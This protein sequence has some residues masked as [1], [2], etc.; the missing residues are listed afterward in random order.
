M[1]EACEHID[2]GANYQEPVPE[3]FQNSRNRQ[4]LHRTSQ[5]L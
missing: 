4:T 5:W 1:S 3:D 2:P